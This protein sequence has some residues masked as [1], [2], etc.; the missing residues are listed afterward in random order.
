MV[1]FGAAGHLATRHLLAALAHLAAARSLPADMRVQG[2]DLAPL[3]TDSYRKRASER[4][5]EPGL[6][7]P[8]ADCE[9]LVRRL[10]YLQA[11]LR[12]GPDLGRVL[13]SGPVIVYLALPPSVYA[14]AVEAI[15]VSGIAPGS[16]IVVEKPFGQDLAS[17]RE[18]TRLLHSISTEKEVFRVDHFLYHQT[19]QDLLALRFANPWFEPCWNRHHVERVEI[20]W[21]ESAGI[22][23]RGEFYDRI[24]ALRDMVQSHLLQIV[25]LV[26]MEPPASLDEP[27]LR[28]ER[29]RALRCVRAMTPHEVATRTTRARYT[30]GSVDGQP[31]PAY[32]KEPGVRRARN[33]ETYVQLELR[34]DAPRWRDVPFVLRT[35]RALGEPQRRIALQ[36][37]AGR[38]ALAHEPLTLSLGMAPHSVTLDLGTAGAAG[39]PSVETVQLRLVRPQQAL[40]ASARLLLDVFEGRSTFVVRDDEVDQCWRVVDSVLATWRSGKPP[41]EE[42]PAGSTGPLHP[43]G[44]VSNDHLG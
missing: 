16:R 8:K 35:G 24:G 4:L 31:Q 14:P 41:L 21:E 22:A 44:D 1:V 25:A 28:D 13:G 36:F 39:L 37:R 30:E 32:A 27:S 23:G 40:P 33:T 19:V 11:D 29:A 3:T 10:D 5:G 6:G 20:T 18:L 34:V 9:S 12:E 26:T 15:R 43:D 42:Y 7:I 38:Q 17:S 2:V